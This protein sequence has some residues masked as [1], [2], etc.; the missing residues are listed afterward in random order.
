MLSEKA[1]E[2]GLDWLR[3]AAFGVLIFYHSGMIFVPWD[4]HIKNPEPSEAL[5]W[6]MVFFNRWRLPLLFFI[7]GCG[8]A[9]SLRRRTWGQFAAERLQ[10]LLIPLV[11]GM[12]VVIPPQIYFERMQQGKPF[13]YREVFDF[14][15]YPQGAFSW[16]HLWFVAYLLVYCLIG[17]PVFAW[18]RG[19]AGKGFTKGMVRLIGR[20]PAAV[21]LINAPSLIVAY[22]LGPRWPVTHNL[23]ADWANFTGSFITFLWGFVIASTPGFLEIIE[24]R[25]REFLIG[26]GLVTACFYALRVAGV[27]SN[28]VSGYMGMLWIFTLVGWAR[29]RIRTGGPWLSYATEA[30]FPFYI[31]HQTIIVTAGFYIIQWPL[32]IGAKLPLTMAV[33]FLGSWL[34]FEIVRRLGPAR[35]LFGLKPLPRA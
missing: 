4:F 7:S 29:A 23:I 24:S 13:A 20:Y 30:V 19:E 11:F 32:S 10:R 9:F 35:V 22:L 27:S 3:V 16:H 1:R 6:V 14:V 31:L 12:F 15:P 18:L 8:V 2:F 5:A 21:Y 33:G 17:I 26:A 34:G 28:V 25:R